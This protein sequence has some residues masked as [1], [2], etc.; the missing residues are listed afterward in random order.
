MGQMFKQMQKKLDFTNCQKTTI[1]LSLN[2]CKCHVRL[3]SRK[4]KKNQKTLLQNEFDESVT[5][6]IRKVNELHHHHRMYRPTAAAMMIEP[7]KTQM[8]KK[9]SFLLSLVHLRRGRR[10]SVG[11]AGGHR[12]P[13][14]QVWLPQRHHPGGAVL[15]RH[16][17]LLKLP[18]PQ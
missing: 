9:K 8:K 12:A 15:R 1:F 4:E 7:F 10:R 3:I 11:S 5:H 2:F 14:H 6:S 13:Q 16:D 18:R 17:P